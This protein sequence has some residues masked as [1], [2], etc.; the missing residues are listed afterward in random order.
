MTEWEPRLGDVYRLTHDPKDIKDPNAVA[1]IRETSDDVET[2]QAVE[3][4]PLSYR[5]CPTF[6]GY[7]VDQQL[8]LLHDSLNVSSMKF[9]VGDF[10][11]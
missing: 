8:K 2:G 3:L 7:M 4:Y 9:D 11:P 5:S 1:V 6:T 10:W